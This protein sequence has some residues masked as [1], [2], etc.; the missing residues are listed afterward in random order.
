MLTVLLLTGTFNDH[1]SGLIIFR[2][3]TDITLFI[4]WNSSYNREHNTGG[5]GGGLI[6]ETIGVYLF[7]KCVSLKITI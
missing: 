7:G 3:K 6:A 4:N 5:K 1:G 2:L